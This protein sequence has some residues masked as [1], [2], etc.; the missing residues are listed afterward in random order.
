MSEQAPRTDSQ[1]GGNHE[2]LFTFLENDPGTGVEPTYGEASG[3]V[4]RQ[5]PTAA[6]LERATGS[7]VAVLER[8]ASTKSERVDARAERVDRAKERLKD[9]GHSALEVAA[10]IT[11]TTASISY[12]R[13][14]AGIDSITKGGAFVQAQLVMLQVRAERRR[15]ERLER[16]RNRDHAEAN[17]MN[18]MYDQE[19]EAGAMND[20]ITQERY[21]RDHG[22]ANQMNAQ[23]DYMNDQH[24][25]AFEMDDEINAERTAERK[26]AAME[27]RAERRERNKARFEK[28]GT[29]T[30]EFGRK[31]LKFGKR[32]GK[33]ALRFVKR[34][35]RAARAAARAA[36]SSWQQAA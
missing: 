4:V 17:Q 9:F 3:E 10:D 33:A 30:R 15:Q 25:Q 24:G 13:L 12:L 32:F 31:A 22:E 7:L 26:Q 11:F 28:A 6:L 16:V 14:E 5:S 35:G 20:Q 36:T 34:S 8:R 18:Y 2:D 29:K 19:T 1:P 23:L 21:D 27:R